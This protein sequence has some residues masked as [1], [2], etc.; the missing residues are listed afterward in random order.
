M[1]VSS[2]M[3]PSFIENPSSKSYGQFTSR[4][5]R[6]SEINLSPAETQSSHSTNELA[7]IECYPDLS[8]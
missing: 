3:P 8:R 6:I 5:S 1:K 7:S 2:R 4:E